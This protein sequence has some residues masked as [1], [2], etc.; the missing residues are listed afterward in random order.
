MSWRRTPTSRWS[1]STR[2]PLSTVH[3]PIQ[4]MGS[5][6][7]A[8]LIRLMDGAPIEQNHIRLPTA[9]VRRGSTAAPR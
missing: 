3:Q 6:A 1:P 5:A 2:T 8:L 4:Q 7:I 9:L